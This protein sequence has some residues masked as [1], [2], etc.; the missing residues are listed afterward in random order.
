MRATG[1]VLCAWLS[2]HSGSPGNAEGINRLVVGV[3]VREMGESRGRAEIPAGTLESLV[4][5]QEGGLGRG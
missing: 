4:S 3:G 2:P 1:E 5:L